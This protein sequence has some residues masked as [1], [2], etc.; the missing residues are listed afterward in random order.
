MNAPESSPE[1]DRIRRWRAVH[2]TFGASIAAKVASI[3]CTFA[4]VPLAVG[5]LGQEAYGFWMALLGIALLMNLVD[6]GIGVGLQRRL[7]EA[8]ARGDTTLFRSTYLTAAASLGAIGLVVLAAGTPVI[9]FADWAVIFK[10]TEP[11]V[12][13]HARAALL[14]V[15]GF[16]A[17]GLPLNATARVAAAVQRGWIQAGWIA[18]GSLVS[19][20]LVALA[21]R[22]DLGFRTFLALACLAPL[23]QGIGLHFHLAHSLGW[24]GRWPALLP[25]GEWRGLLGESL[26]FSAPQ[27]GLA[28]VQSLPPVMMALAA[29]PVIVT[30]YNL[31]QRLFSL[32][33]QGQV[34]LLTPI[35]PA[36]TEACVRGDGT[37]VR[38]A[39]AV[40]LAATVAFAAALAAVAFASPWLIRLWVGSAA[41][42][43]APDLIWSAAA[44]AVVLLAQQPLIYLIVGLGRLR[45]LALYGTL[46][47]AA[48]VVGMFVGSYL[49]GAPGILLG[50]A[51]GGLVIGIPGMCIETR[52]ALAQMTAH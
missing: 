23:F 20:G 3:L 5:Y 45:G 25:R 12:A 49:R 33:A 52:R 38:K 32:V 10:L 17:I 19:L 27:L 21:V 30:A 1:A 26:F 47:Y 9:L 2:L 18:A 36:Y 37:W 51:A 34:M 48:S 24:R 15:I 14:I 7:A 44:W 6:F 8:W 39:F 43:P 16:F 42:T 29:G 46:G 41:A 35:W 13:G 31:L 11:A 22:F 28:L 40:S 50:A 4:Q